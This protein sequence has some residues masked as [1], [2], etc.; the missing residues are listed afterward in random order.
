M[1]VNKDEQ[2]K[3]RSIKLL[4]EIGINNC[5][6]IPD[7]DVSNMCIRSK[8]DISKRAISCL[9]CIQAS[10][11]N[12]KDYQFYINK[13]KKFNVDESV[14]MDY[15]KEVFSGEIS[16]DKLKL[17]AWKYE[18]YWVLCW[19]LGFFTELR[20]PK[21]VCNFDRAI[22]FTFYCDNFEDFINKVN[23]VDTD[24][25]LDEFDF[26]SRLY[27]ECLNG[28]SNNEVCNSI[29]RDIVAERYMALKWILYP[30]ANWYII[31]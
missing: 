1:F 8:E 28:K 11:E 16:D 25:I 19:V 20:A 24:K 30:D 31:E 15:E 18:A 10:L 3:N 14:L 9:F 26:I 29:L 22:D 12:R 13:L 7:I 2:R 6:D 23:L 4:K 27:N 17:V 5:L 21:E